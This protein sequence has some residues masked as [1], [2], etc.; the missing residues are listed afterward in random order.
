MSPFLKSLGPNFNTTKPNGTVPSAVLHEVHPSGCLSVRPSLL[1]SF[2]R[3]S[4]PEDCSSHPH[5]HMKAGSPLRFALQGPGPTFPLVL[6]SKKVNATLHDRNS[7][8]ILRR[9]QPE[10]FFFAQSN[11]HGGSTKGGVSPNQGMNLQKEQPNP[12]SEQKNL[13]CWALTGHLQFFG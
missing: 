2:V 3:D 13:E 6:R 5:H 1:A 4:I 10:R 8:R 12:C 11:E 9:S 7:L